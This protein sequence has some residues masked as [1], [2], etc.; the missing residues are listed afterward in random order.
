MKDIIIQYD[1]TILYIR[2][3]RGLGFLTTNITKKPAS[4]YHP[5]TLAVLDRYNQ[6]KSAFGTILNASNRLLQNFNG[7]FYQLTNFLMASHKHN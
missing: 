2:D 5:G 6:A 1:G 4:Q 3:H 7:I